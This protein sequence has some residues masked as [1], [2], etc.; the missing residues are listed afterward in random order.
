[1]HQH[2]GPALRLRQ[3]WTLVVSMASVWDVVGQKLIILLNTHA[4][5]LAPRSPGIS[6][7]VHPDGPIANSSVRPDRFSIPRWY[8]RSTA[9]RTSARRAARAPRYRHTARAYSS[10]TR[11]ATNDHNLIDSGTGTHIRPGARATSRKPYIIRNSEQSSPIVGR[12]VLER[13]G[14][15]CY[16]VQNLRRAICCKSAIETSP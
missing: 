14:P 13:L 6:P 8:R 4:S 15:L 1:M 16:D 9:E 2:G 10:L 5:V 12:T 7:L 3:Q 11:E